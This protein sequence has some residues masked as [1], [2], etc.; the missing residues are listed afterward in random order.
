MAAV[1]DK[2]ARDQP[3][4]GCKHSGSGGKSI[5]RRGARAQWLQSLIG[6][7]G[8]NHYRGASTVV[9]AARA[10]AAGVQGHSG[11]SH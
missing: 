7:L 1:I 3:L 6:Q 5:S 8:I 2:A 9:V 4:P 11:C 10:S